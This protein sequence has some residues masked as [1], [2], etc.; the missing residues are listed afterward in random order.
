MIH[1][2]RAVGPENLTGFPA[3]P[4]ISHYDMVYSSMVLCQSPLSVHQNRVHPKGVE[5]KSII[6]LL[7]GNNRF[8]YKLKQIYSV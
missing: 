2:Q 5:A 6:L 8:S 4:M 3:A 7:L 1:R